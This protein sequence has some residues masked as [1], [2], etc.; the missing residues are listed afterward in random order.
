MIA[1]LH[2]VVANDPSLPLFSASGVNFRT[3]TMYTRIPARL[4][5]EC[6]ASI[7]PHRA[8]RMACLDEV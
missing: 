3:I 7:I 4:Q 2:G 8:G 6:I 5:K 1:E